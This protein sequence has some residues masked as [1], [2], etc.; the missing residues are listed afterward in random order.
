MFGLLPTKHSGSASLGP[1]S[2]SYC[3]MTTRNLITAVA[4]SN[5]VNTHIVDWPEMYK[6]IIFLLYC[7]LNEED[8]M[9]NPIFEVEV[10]VDTME[11]T[12]H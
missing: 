1:E 5:V 11:T 12:Y 7:S 10:E 6:G 9:K 8:K 3:L 4:V 2:S